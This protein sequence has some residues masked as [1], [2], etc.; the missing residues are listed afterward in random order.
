VKSVAMEATG[1]YWI[2]LYEIL[3][4]R[5]FDVVLVNAKHVKNV[6]GRKRDVLDCDCVTSSPGRGTRMRSHSTGTL[7]AG[8]PTPRS[9]RR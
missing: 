4:G 6:P 1:V 8:P 5:G 3:E 7:V 9:S 2:P